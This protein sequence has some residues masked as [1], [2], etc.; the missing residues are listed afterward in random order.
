MY[1]GPS[2]SGRSRHDKQIVDIAKTTYV[3]EAEGIAQQGETV[4]RKEDGSNKQIYP[5][6]VTRKVVWLKRGRDLHEE[7]EMPFV[8]QPHALI[9]P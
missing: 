8:M 7:N 4:V 9:N 6:S 1:N 5:V 3:C 2:F